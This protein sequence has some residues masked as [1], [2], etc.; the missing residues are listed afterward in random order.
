MH[1]GIAAAEGDDPV[2]HGAAPR[3][4]SRSRCGL[5]LGTIAIAIGLQPSKISPLASAIASSLP[6]FSMCAGAMAVTIAT[7]GRTSRVS[8][9][10]SPALFMPISSTAIFGVARHPREAQRNAGVIVVA[11][12][13]A[14]DAARAR[15]RSSAAYER[16][17]G[18]GLA[19]RSGDADDLAPR[20]ARAP[21]GRASSSASS[22][23]S[24]STCGPRSA[25]TRSRRRRPRR[26]PGRRSGGRR[27]PCPASP[28]TG[29]PAPTSR[30]SKVTP[31]TSNAR[32][33]GAAGRLGDFG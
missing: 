9:A 20:S 2:R 13:R 16:F 10:I 21:R 7:C 29:R 3:V 17:L 31:V 14:V 8:A 19:D 1:V 4:T 32:A 24:T 12:D 23:S 26:K 5:S 33:R 15:Q 27:G 22:V 30:L 11:L 18:A 6:R 28:R 25:A